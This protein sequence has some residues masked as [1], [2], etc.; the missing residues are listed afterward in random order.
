MSSTW[1]NHQDW[2]TVVL[3]KK[4]VVEHGNERPQSA[5]PASGINRERNKLMTSAT[6]KMARTIEKRVDD[7]DGT[8][9][10]IDYVNKD[11]AKAIANAR[12]KA[13]L[14]QKMLAQK[15]CISEKDVKEIESGKAVEH[16]QR[17]SSIKRFLGI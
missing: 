4:P 15:L 16:K 11:V 17:I 2:E 10:P 12:I 13:G 1:V 9:A 8:K 5:P 3:R 6:T 7:P 14:S